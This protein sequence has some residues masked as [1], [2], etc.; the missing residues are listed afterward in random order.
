MS[1]G[2]GSNINV[3]IN[4]Y[5]EVYC[6]TQSREGFDCKLGFLAICLGKG[7]LATGRLTWYWLHIC[8]PQG[9]F[10]LNYVNM[11]EF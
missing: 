8:P 11:G 9:Y 6:R 2:F 3:C 5:W 1:G 10:M 4:V 7:I